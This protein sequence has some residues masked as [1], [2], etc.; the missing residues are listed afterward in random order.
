MK[1]I[2]MTKYGFVRWPE[3]DFS[4]D[5]NRFQCYKVGKRVRVSKLVTNGEVYISARI[6]GNRLPFNVYKALPHYH[7]LDKLNGV[8]I[9]SLT[10]DDLFDLVEA[11]VLYEKEYTE[12]EN[13]I[14]MPTIDEIRQQCL[15]IQAKVRSELTEINQHFNIAFVSKVAEWEWREIRRQLLSL[16]ARIETF[17]PATYPQTILGTSR[18]ID[19]CKPTCSELKDSYYFTWIMDKINK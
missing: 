5:G 12:A 10:D 16:T 19:F 13:S 14:V 6:D 4:D 15:K 7:S 8:S 18:S 17:N 9:A 3:E 2:M 1:K 11:C